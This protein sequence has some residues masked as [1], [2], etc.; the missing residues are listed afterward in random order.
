MIHRQI[1]RNETFLHVYNVLPQPSVW[2]TVVLLL[3]PIDL[4]KICE[5]IIYKLYTYIN[6]SYRC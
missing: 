1:E 4:P 6:T 3:V 2:A 5:A